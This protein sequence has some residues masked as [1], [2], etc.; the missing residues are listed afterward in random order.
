MKVV[1]LDEMIPEQSEMGFAFS[2]KGTVRCGC[3]E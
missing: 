2:R 3:D 1:G